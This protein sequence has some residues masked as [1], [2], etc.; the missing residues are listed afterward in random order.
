MAL[1]C[2]PA[3]P[4]VHTPLRYFV[5]LC[6]SRIYHRHLPIFWKRKTMPLQNTLHHQVPVLRHFAF[7]LSDMTTQNNFL[8]DHLLCT[9]MCAPI[10]TVCQTLLFYPAVHIPSCHMTFPRFSHHDCRYPPYI[11]YH[12][13]LHD[14]N[15]HHHYHRISY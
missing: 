7:R 8:P 4:C 10:S 11:P 3:H 14:K 6:C 12:H 5:P 15:A 13:R 2:V 1:R 9:Y